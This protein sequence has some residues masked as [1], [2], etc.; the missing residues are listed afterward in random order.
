MLLAHSQMEVIADGDEHADDGVVSL[1]E[2]DE[3]ME[4]LVD[5]HAGGDHDGLAAAGDVG[6]VEGDVLAWVREQVRRSEW[7]GH[8]SWRSIRRGWKWF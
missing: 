3:G 2:A 6:E 8:R 5:V 7:D 1:E 4:S